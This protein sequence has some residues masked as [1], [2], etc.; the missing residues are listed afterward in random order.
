[1]APADAVDAAGGAE[2][3]IVAVRPTDENLAQM[4]SHVKWLAENMEEYLGDKRY[5]S[6][7]R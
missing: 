4:V 7:R 6:L 3:S 1:M 2:D 5:K